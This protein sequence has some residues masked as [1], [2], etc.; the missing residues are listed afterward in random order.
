[1]RFGLVIVAKAAEEQIV[2]LQLSVL[3]GVVAG[4]HAADPDHHPVLIFL[5]HVGELF[6]RP[7]DM[8][9]VGL[10]AGGDA[11][12]AGD[13]HRDIAGLCNGGEALGAGLETDFIL[14]VIGD[15]QRGDVSP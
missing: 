10:D 15:D 2:G 13:H 8:N 5:D 1:M 11:R 7:L 12:R 14:S 4:F 9:A 3:K 6:E